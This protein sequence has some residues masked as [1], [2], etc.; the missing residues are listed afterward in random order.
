MKPVVAITALSLLVILSACTSQPVQSP[1]IR[2]SSSLGSTATSPATLAD[3]LTRVVEPVGSVGD[4][5][6]STG[7]VMP[8]ATL[9][10]SD[11]IV[12]IPSTTETVSVGSNDAV[13]STIEVTMADNGRTL[14]LNVGDGFLLNLG[15][16]FY[17]WSVEIDNQAV[18][19]RELNISVIKGAQEIYRTRS[20]GTATLSATGSPQCMNLTP[21]CMVPSILFRIDLIVQ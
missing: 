4:D 12:I 7:I 20:S 10:P 13:P 19:S 18:V 6:S 3:T 16:D 11:I 21:P 1:Q 15:S 5:I 2:I 17:D 8:S 14:Q 9:P